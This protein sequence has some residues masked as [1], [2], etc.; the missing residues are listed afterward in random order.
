MK[1]L[2]LLAFFVVGM[3]ANAENLNENI[4]TNGADKA[5]VVFDDGDDDIN[6]GGVKIAEGKDDDD[7][8]SMHFAVGGIITTG[9]PDDVKFSYWRSWDINWT[10]IQYDYRPKKSKLSLSAGLGFNWRKY[11]L[12]GHKDMFVKE[13]DVVKVAPVGTGMDDLSS[14]IHTA[15]L[16]MP[17][18]AK[19]SFGKNIALSL[20]AQLNWNYYGRL[21][22]SYEHG[23]NDYKIFTKKIGQRPFTVDIMGIVHVWDIGIYCKYSPMSVLKKDRGIEFKSVSI[24]VYF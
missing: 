14:D 23:D 7:R 11:P 21:H 22:S 5:I 9:A 17:L 19:Y 10:I 12:S 15:S 2:L 3:T 18:L 4:A 24:G 8:W 16:S 1:Y 20:G 6:G 13:G